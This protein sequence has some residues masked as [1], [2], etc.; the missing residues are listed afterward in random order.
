MCYT[1]R[2]VVDKCHHQPFGRF[3]SEAVHGPAYLVGA[4][5]VAL[6]TLQL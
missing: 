5:D 1:H 4:G 3:G 6:T 2:Y